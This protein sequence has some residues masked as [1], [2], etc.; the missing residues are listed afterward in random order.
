MLAIRKYPY[1]IYNFED[2]KPMLK[3]PLRHE[4]A[5]SIN[6]FKSS[7]KI[8]LKRKN[9]KFLT[10]KTTMIINDDNNFKD[11]DYINRYNEIIAKYNVNPSSMKMNLW[12]F[13]ECLHKWI[14]VKPT[15]MASEW[16]TKMA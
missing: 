5:F 7:V 16:L 12:K 13:F 1:F 6:N 8:D 14:W 15:E 2:L 11:E 4:T 3:I 9:N 10:T